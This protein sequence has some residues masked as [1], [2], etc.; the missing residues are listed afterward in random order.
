MY[1]NP[2]RFVVFQMD[3]I[4]YRFPLLQT[5]IEKHNDLQASSG[6]WINNVRADEL[7]DTMKG[8]P[9]STFDV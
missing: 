8:I 3:R 1:N 9:P 2:V 4:R 7:H 6:Y 5:L